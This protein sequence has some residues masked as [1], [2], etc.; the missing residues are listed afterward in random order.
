VL[1]ADDAAHPHLPELVKEFLPASNL[2][3]INPG[4]NAPGYPPAVFFGSEPAHAWCYFYQ[5]ASLAVQTGNWEQASWLGDQAASLG[6]SPLSSGSN[7]PQEWLP[8]IEGYVRTG[9]VET[10]RDL[11]R[12]AYEQDP[13]Y[14]PRL[15]GLW[16]SLAIPV[17]GEAEEIDDLLGCQ[18]VE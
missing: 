7:S 17:A 2:E 14:G 13:K 16:R 6:Y 5:K 1:S 9:R 10:A 11:T 8:F 3:R 15:C 4:E 18:N 12:Q